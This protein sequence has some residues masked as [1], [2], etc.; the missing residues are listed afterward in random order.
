M[1]FASTEG[2]GPDP[3]HPHVL[4]DL[5]DW[6]THYGIRTQ[7][8]AMW[9]ER[10]EVDRAAYGIYRP[11]F[12]NHVYRDL[13]ISRAHTEPFNRSLDDRSTQHGK[14]AVDRFVFRGIRH[15]SRMPLT[16]LSA[17]DP[18][19]SAVSHFRDVRVVDPADDERR[20][21]VGSGGGPR[22]ELSTMTEKRAYSMI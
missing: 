20:A 18:S 7:L 17:N 19:G 22:L 16:Q 10:V 2:V 6:E 5:R 4:R 9:L 3:R 14:I 11:G 13:T 21:I 8:P 12:G 15:S 1:A